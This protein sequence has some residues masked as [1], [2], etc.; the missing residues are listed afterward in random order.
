M[1]GPLQ[2]SGAG[3][4]KPDAQSAQIGRSPVADPPDASTANDPLQ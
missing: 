2:S 3:S 4:W 1:V